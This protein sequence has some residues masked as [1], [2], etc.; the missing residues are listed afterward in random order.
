MAIR[1][2]ARTGAWLMALL[3]V[4]PAAGQQ[5]YTYQVRHEHW[6]KFCAGTLT[7]SAGGVTYA[8]APGKKKEKLHHFTWKYPDIQQLSLAPGRVTVLTYDDVRLKFGADRE[9][10]FDLG[11][12]QT[13]EGAYPLLSKLDQRFVAEFPLAVENPEWS[14]PVK[15]LYRLGGSQGEL[16]AGADR[17]VY[18]TAKPEESRT[19]RFEDIESISTGGPFSLTLTTFERSRAH[20]GSR[21]DFHFQLKEAMPEARFQALWQK[22]ESFHTSNALARTQ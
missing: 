4:V 12:G 14:I 9:F 11:K 16:L 15:H 5:G 6:R 13:F 20:Y 18:R 2:E 10:R 8:E 1:I 7:I 19:W 21:K 3:A 22:L 17:I